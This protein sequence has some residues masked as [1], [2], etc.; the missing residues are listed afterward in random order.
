M[1]YTLEIEQ[2]SAVYNPET[3]IAYIAY[4]GLLSSEVTVEVYAWL[5]YLYRTVGAEGFY[6]QIFDF[7]GVE[8]FAPSNITTARRVSNR[9]NMI[10]DTS[11]IPVGLI[12]GNFYHEQMLLSAMRVSPENVRKKIVW[13][14][15]EALSFFEQKHRDWA[16]EHESS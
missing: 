5:E 7:T 6:G 12:V 16:A 15:A 14:E 13:S 8:E 11:H 1:N 10:I 4:R 3:R 2:A 9:I